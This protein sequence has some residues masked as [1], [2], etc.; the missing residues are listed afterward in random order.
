[1]NLLLF[2]VYTI[3]IRTTHACI[4]AYFYNLLVVPENNRFFAF[5]M[6]KVNRIT[7]MVECKFY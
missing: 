5:L 7:Y 2:G 4:E 6:V 3:F 1:M